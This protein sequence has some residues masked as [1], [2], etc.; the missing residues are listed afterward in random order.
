MNLRSYYVE[1]VERILKSIVSIFRR[2]S[3]SEE[4]SNGFIACVS[5]LCLGFGIEIT[6]I[7]KREL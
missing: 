2:G 3:H 4:Y 5:A 6:D 7:I 1:D